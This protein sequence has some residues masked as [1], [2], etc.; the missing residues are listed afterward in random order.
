M[1]AIEAAWRI[2]H[3]AVRANSP[4]GRAAAGIQDHLLF[5]EGQSIAWAARSR[6]TPDKGDAR[7]HRGRH[8]RR[9]KSP[10]YRTAPGVRRG[11]GRAHRPC[12]AR[13]LD[14]LIPRAAAASIPT[15]SGN[16]PI[17]PDAYPTGKNFYRI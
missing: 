3:S 12:G 9:G 17:N 16:E 2:C 4:G 6:R 10:L 14:G 5:H 11:H 1:I 13:E 15:S 8:R 7:Q